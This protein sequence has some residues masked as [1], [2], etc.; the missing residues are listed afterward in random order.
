MQPARAV[1]IIGQ[2][3][4]ALHAAHKIGLVH[5]DVK[6]S[7][8]LLDD[9]DFAYLIDF[10]IARA[11]D[12]TRL[13]RTGHAIGTFHYMA[14][15]RLSDRKDDDGRADIY[16]L[17]CVLYE[18][19]TGQ[20]PFADDSMGSLV[21]AHLHAPPP[22]PSTCLPDV[23]AQ[24]DQAIATGMAKDRDQRYATTVELASAALR[25]HYHPHPGTNPTANGHGTRHLRCHH[26][27]R[28]S[29]HRHDGVARTGRCYASHTK[30]GFA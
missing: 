7:N 2:V 25:R 1:R 21:A 5:R 10:G 17:T 20:P 4:K 18:C 19:L 12:E 8:I 26:G 3:A 11:T 22:Q 27:G 23:P 28:R 30:N 29:R 9:D 14:P 24:L 15:E 13:T 16:A 6:P